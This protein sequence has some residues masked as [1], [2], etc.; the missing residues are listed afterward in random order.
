MINRAMYPRPHQG[1]GLT[2]GLLHLQVGAG[3]DLFPTGDLHPDAIR[4]L[5]VAH[6]QLHSIH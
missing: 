5:L 1:G 4:R 2:A 3:R 6:P